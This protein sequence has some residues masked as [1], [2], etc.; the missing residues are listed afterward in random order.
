MFSLLYSSR[1]RCAVTAFSSSVVLAGTAMTPPI[2]SGA[3][4]AVEDGPAGEVGMGVA[5]EMGTVVEATCIC[6][7]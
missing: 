4:W 2:L 5:D 7:S 3:V 6:R 1:N